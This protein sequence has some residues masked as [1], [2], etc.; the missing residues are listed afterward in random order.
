MENI[1]R[2]IIGFDEISQ[3]S[4]LPIEKVEKFLDLIKR[5]MEPVSKRI[6]VLENGTKRYYQ[7]ERRG[8]GI[9]NTP[10]GKFWEYNFAID[11]QWQKYSVLVKSDI[12][13]E[14]LIPAFKN[15]ESLIL[16]TD[17]G[18]ETGQLYKDLTCECGEQLHLA[19]KTISE[20]AEG[21]IVSIPSQDGR[22]MG[23][24]FKLATLW[25]QEVLNLDTVESA[26]LLAPGGVIDVRTYSGVICILKFFNIQESCVI[27][28]ATNN[29]KKAEVF[30]ENGYI[31]GSYTPIVIK[32]NGYTKIHLLAKQKFLG[33]KNL[34][35]DHEGGE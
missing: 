17:S 3:K 16:R 4:S 5:S 33:H 19:M 21:M 24:T 14:L 30:I 1:N 34:V 13:E 25:V 9:L 18:C 32:P 22:G 23:L 20:S 28:L 11:D 8:I 6:S 2:K 12:D 7:V 26:T 15:K 31:I 35:E 27:N 10:Y 29:P